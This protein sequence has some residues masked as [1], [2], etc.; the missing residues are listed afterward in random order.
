MSKYLNFFFTLLRDVFY[1]LSPDFLAGYKIFKL[2]KWWMT[3]QPCTAIIKLLYSG[4]NPWMI[5]LFIWASPMID[6]K[7]SSEISRQIDLTLWS[8]PSNHHVALWDWQLGS[9]E[10]VTSYHSSLRKA[11]RTC[12]M[13][14]TVFCHPECASTSLLRPR[15][16][17]QTLFYLFWFSIYPHFPKP[18]F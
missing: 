11:L 16:S 15:F 13:L 18:S 17:R 1:L 6:F 14:L 12:L 5:I 2:Y 9:P 4:H 7:S 10:V 3:G 8:I